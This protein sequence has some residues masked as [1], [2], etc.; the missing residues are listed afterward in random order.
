MKSNSQLATERLDKAS[1]AYNSKAANVESNMGIIASN[2]AIAESNMAN[3]TEVR[4]A[5]IYIGSAIT[6]L[7]GLIEVN[8][9]I[10]DTLKVLVTVLTPKP[11]PKEIDV[12]PPTA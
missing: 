10:A 4:E 9:Q 12:K 1:S 7:S 5:A 6:L 8:Q 11:D 3:V 2:L